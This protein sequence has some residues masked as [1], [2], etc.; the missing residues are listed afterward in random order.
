MGSHNFKGAANGVLCVLQRMSRDIQCNIYIALEIS[1]DIQCNIYISPDA[2]VI[3]NIV[4]K[5]AI[6]NNRAWQ[7]IGYNCTRWVIG[8]NSTQ[9]GKTSSQRTI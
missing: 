7:T 6:A 2:H 4:A 8:T 5:N 9:W 3:V 1:R